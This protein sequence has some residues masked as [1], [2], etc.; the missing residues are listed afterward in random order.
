MRAFQKSQDD[1]KRPRSEV[2]STQSAATAMLL[3]ADADDHSLVAH[4]NSTSNCAMD[5]DDEEIARAIA[6]SIA[7]SSCSSSNT[8]LSSASASA[9]ADTSAPNA[10]ELSDE[11]D[12]LIPIP[13]N[14]DLLQQMLAMGFS[15]IRSRKGL[16]TAQK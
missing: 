6:L 14:E 12:E 7:A 9:S 10:M 16:Y 5:E 8:E 2:S 11:G 15:D 13:V 1:S 4:S 3:A